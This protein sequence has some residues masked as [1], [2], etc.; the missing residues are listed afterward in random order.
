MNW[1]IMNGAAEEFLGD[2]DLEEYRR[3]YKKEL[4]EVSEE[5]TEESEAEAW[6]S[7]GI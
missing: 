7:V 2:D 1:T 5:D 6:E 3:K 4:G